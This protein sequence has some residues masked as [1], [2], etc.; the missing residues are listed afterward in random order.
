MSPEPPH[1]AGRHFLLR[2][3]KGADVWEWLA[4]FCARE[5]VKTAAVQIIG[6]TEEVTIG[7]YDQVRRDYHK[8]TF[9]QEMEILSCAGNVSLKD[10][11][12]FPHLH[13]CMGD[14]ELKVWGGHLFAG[15]KVFAAE[16][17]VVELLGPER[18]RLPDAATGLTLWR[19]P[20]A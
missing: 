20:E 3:P 6:A 16:A 8:R 1:S 17:H 14:V 19:C 2:L 9:R 7:Y 12:P 15:S 5:S 4:D 10:G 13:A 11:K 18:E